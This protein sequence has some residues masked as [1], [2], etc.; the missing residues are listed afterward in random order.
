MKR[1]FLAALRAGVCAVIYV[2]L[3]PFLVPWW[4]FYACARLYFALDALIWRLRDK[5]TRAE[6]KVRYRDL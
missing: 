4:I 6:D 5:F 1:I 2:L 3:L